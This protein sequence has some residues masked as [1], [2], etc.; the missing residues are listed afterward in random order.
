[1]SFIIWIH[2]SAH[3]SP[4]PVI[5][6]R[7]ERQSFFLFLFFQ[8]LF[9]SS[10]KSPQ[11]YTLFCLILSSYEQFGFFFSKDKN[12][13]PLLKIIWSFYFFRKPLDTIL[14]FHKFR[15]HREP[16]CTLMSEKSKKKTKKNKIWWY[17][18]RPQK[19]NREIFFPLNL[20]EIAF[21]HNVSLF[22]CFLSYRPLL[23]Y[24]SK[25]QNVIFCLILSPDYFSKRSKTT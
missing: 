6:R 1:M 4:Q 23:I 20:C 3:S 12:L 15:F 24:Q 16:K 25:F 5:Y 22:D 14:N 7:L 8:R 9:T 11:L 21:R 2:K 13:S 19:E 10:D 18:C 17:P